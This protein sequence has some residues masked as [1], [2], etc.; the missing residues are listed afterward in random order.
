MHIEH[1][2]DFVSDYVGNKYLVENID[3]DNKIIT[4]TTS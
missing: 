3:H 4:I 1:V 2:E